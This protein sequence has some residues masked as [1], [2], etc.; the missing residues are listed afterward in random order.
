MKKEGYL[1][2]NGYKTWYVVY[3]DL[4]NGTI[5]L[6]GLHGGPGWPHYSLE[7]LAQLTEQ[8][9]PVILYDQLGCG[10]SDR[11]DDPNLWTIELFVNELKVLKDALGLSTFNLLG[12]SWGGTLALEYLF[13][14]NQEVEKLILNSPLLDTKLWVQEADKLKDQLSP[15][16]AE[17]MRKHEAAGTTD[18][19]EYK[20]AYE[21]FKENFVCRI[22]PQPALHDMADEE[23]GETVYRTMWGPSEAYSNGTLKDYSALDKL[24]GVKIPTLLISG[25]HDEAT[26]L[27]MSMAQKA[28]PDCNWLLLENSSHSSLFEETDKYLSAVSAFLAKAR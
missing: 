10:K 28:I 7:P 6:I 4:S 2:F 9:I 8:G 15:E 5:P 3:G 25:K 20:A 21:Q 26:P 22:V 14:H 11:P 18:N 1:D 24:S 23:W 16:V 27:Q 19:P 17:M 12:H 13:K